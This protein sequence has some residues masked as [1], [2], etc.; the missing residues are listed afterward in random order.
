V[1]YRNDI[2]AMAE[3]LRGLDADVEARI[4][5]NDW[6]SWASDRSNAFAEVY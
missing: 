3:R 6:T 4:S 5:G 1:A 2:D